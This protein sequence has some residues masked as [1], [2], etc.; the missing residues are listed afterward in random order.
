MRR[1]A[2]AAC[3][4]LAFLVATSEVNSVL[5]DNDAPPFSIS[6]KLASHIH[7]SDSVR[8]EATEVVAATIEAL[9]TTFGPAANP[10]NK[11]GALTLVIHPDADAY[12][13]AVRRIGAKRFEENLAVTDYD[14]HESHVAIQ[15]T[16]SAAVLSA[17][18]LPLLTRRQIAHETAHLWCDARWP[19][20]YQDA[21]Q[22]LREGVATWASES[23]MRAMGVIAP[24]EDDPFLSTRIVLGQHAVGALPPTAAP[25]ATFDPFARFD[26]R[27]QY[28]LDWLWVR[29]LIDSAAS[30]DRKGAA[31]DTRSIP[32]DRLVTWF[33][34]HP[35]AT[36][37]A[38]TK[39]VRSLQPEWA[40]DARSLETRGN[41]MI[42]R[43]F[44]SDAALAWR[45]RGPTSTPYLIRGSFQRLA[46]TNAQ[47]SVYFA[48]D[49][50]GYLAA[51][52]RPGEGIAI[53][54]F[55]HKTGRWDQLAAASSIRLKASAP[56]RFELVV[57]GQLVT[58]KAGGRTA[59]STTVSDKR[60]TGPWGVSVEADHAV[61]WENVHVLSG[62]N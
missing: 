26:Q 48:R 22:W 8:H 33:T 56:C 29:M 17:I 53:S 6:V 60:M 50:F 7:H 49:A 39:Y 38:F 11:S 9:D 51:T 44:P 40:Q 27:T 54:R 23:A 3:T 59:C 32:A 62:K 18:G 19:H 4:C 57:D 16:P 47:V 28:A 15:P 42:Q 1:Y 25:S 58:L 41:E 2:L 43:S 10:G 34:N 46:S 30:S 12:K 37:P 55:R 35:N 20:G 36:I 24:A 52:F 13:K 61:R 14:R 21:P 31:I 5:A 45:I